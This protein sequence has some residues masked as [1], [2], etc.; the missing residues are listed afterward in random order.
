MLVQKF[1][2]ITT[3]STEKCRA[4]GKAPVPAPITSA[5]VNTKKCN[6]CHAPGWTY[7]HVCANTAV[8]SSAAPYYHHIA[9]LSKED[10]SP[11]LAPMFGL[12]APADSSSPIVRRDNNAGI[13]VTD[14]STS[15]NNDMIA[16]I[17]RQAQAC[18]YHSIFSLSPVNKSN[19]LII[20]LYYKTLGRT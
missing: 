8:R 13:T 20:P 3:H 18:K 15:L 9:A 1:G 12:G 7:G 19:M 16:S 5:V 2:V 11:S 10:S 4:A 14:D 17:A 6:T